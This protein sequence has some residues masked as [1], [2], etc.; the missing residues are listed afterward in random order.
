MGGPPG[1]GWVAPRPDRRIA[2]NLR[3]RHR[4]PPES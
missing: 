1:L 3:A 4:A 2:R